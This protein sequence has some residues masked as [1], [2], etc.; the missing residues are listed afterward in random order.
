MQYSHFGLLMTDSSMLWMKDTYGHIWRKSYVMVSIFKLM[1]L[2]S[3]LSPRVTFIP[4]IMWYDSSRHHQQRCWV[5]LYLYDQHVHAHAY[6]L[7]SFR[8]RFGSCVQCGSVTPRESCEQKKCSGCV[9]VVTS[10]VMICYLLPVQT[11]PPP[12]PLPSPHHFKL[13]PLSG[14]IMCWIFTAMS[15]ALIFIPCLPADDDAPMEA[16]FVATAALRNIAATSVAFL[17]YRALVSCR[18]RWSIILPQR[19]YRGSK[20]YWKSRVFHFR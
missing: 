13:F 16:Q 19:P 9:S 1:T 15:L 10:T 4:S 17:L 8:S 3:H 12:P 2:S 7:R 5:V 18:Q 6:P 14:V 20:N 11:P